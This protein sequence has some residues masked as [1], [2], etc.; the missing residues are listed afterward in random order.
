MPTYAALEAE[1]WWGAE[2]EAPAHAEFNARMRE[3]FHLSAAAAGS[4]GDDNHLY[5]RHR[6]R[7]W[8]LNS[9][10]CT[11]RAYGTQD[12]RDR[13]GDG[14][15]LRASDI[16][17]SG[18]THWA[19][20]RR[21]DAAVRA[22]R[23][24]GLAEWFGTFDGRSVSGW[25]EGHP[26]SSDDSHL[27]H[28]HVGLWTNS[29]NDTATLR[30]LGDII[31]G[32][33]T[34]ATLQPNGGPDMFIAHLPAA[35]NGG[36]NE[37]WVVGPQGR[38]RLLVDSFKVRNIFARGG[39]PTV[40]LSADDVPPKWTMKNVLDALGPVVVAPVFAGPGGVTVPS[41]Y[42]L[43]LTGNAEAAP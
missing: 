34:A 13:T 1:S 11:D 27:W 38:Y 7:S 17:I 36:K 29:C 24:P 37:Y 23:L 9:R 28:L 25:F 19:A 2:H 41:H 32:V 26:S 35:L 21:L 5:G 15:W 12:A 3:A 14:N 30:L 31:L 33:S 20:A 22:G 18:Q 43:T 42:T 10:W 40:E 39:C 4:K 16:G 8:D 6:S